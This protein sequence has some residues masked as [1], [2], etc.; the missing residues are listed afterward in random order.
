MSVSALID[1]FDKEIEAT[2][3]LKLQLQNLQA[4]IIEIQLNEGHFILLSKA[5]D[6][7]NRL[8]TL[9]RVTEELRD[10]PEAQ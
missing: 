8:L 1:F 5:I 2:N 10:I 7:I 6:H 9:I 3:E 4:S